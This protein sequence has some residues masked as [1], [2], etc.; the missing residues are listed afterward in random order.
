M[1]GQQNI[2]KFKVAFTEKCQK[3]SLGISCGPLRFCGAH[4]FYH[5]QIL[6]R[7]FN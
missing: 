1:H 4:G 5:C 6:N 7:A 2:K 3:D